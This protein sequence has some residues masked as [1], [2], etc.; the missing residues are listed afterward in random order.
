MGNFGRG[1]SRGGGGGRGGFDR[2]GSDSRN[3]GPRQM[4]KTVC[5]NC[6]K[7]CE[8]PFR[9]SGD[10]P[11]YCSDCFR[12]NQESDSPRSENRFP[13][14]PRFENRRDSGERNFSQPDN[15]DQFLTLNNKLDKVLKLLTLVIN[16]TQTQTQSQPVKAVKI[17]E[18][19]VEIAVE[20]PVETP[21]KKTTTAKKTPASKKK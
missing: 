13:S 2:R 9:P 8:V 16:S 12:N 7:D 14:N 20:A 17:V 21:K 1:N 4:F 6:S 15:K 18:P 11:V 5:S 19:K 3:T 10:K